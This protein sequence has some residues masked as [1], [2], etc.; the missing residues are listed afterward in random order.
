MAHKTTLTTLIK[1]FVFNFYSYSESIKV[2]LFIEY[3]LR[4][5]FK[6]K[7]MVLYII[8]DSS[9]SEILHPDIICKID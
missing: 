1:N 6:F 7:R 4:F 8:A 3:I 9:A 5:F 2:L